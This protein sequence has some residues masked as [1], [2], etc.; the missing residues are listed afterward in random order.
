MEIINKKEFATAALNEDNK[1]FVLHMAAPSVNSN[2]LLFWQA[3]IA[4]LDVEKI[5]IP[6]EYLDYTNVLSPDS[7][8]ELP[9]HT[10]INNH[11]INLIDDKQ[12]PYGP[13]YSLRLVELEMLKTYIKTNLA[14][15][16]IRPSKSSTG[17]SILFIHKKDGSF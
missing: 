5:T 14:N 8:A 4:S 16:F 11:L 15:G 1:I 3:Q 10:G 9:K 17:A 7:A 13:I 2:V 6:A 12:L